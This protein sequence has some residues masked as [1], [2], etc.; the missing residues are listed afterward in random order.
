MINPYPCVKL[1]DGVECYLKEEN[2]L[3]TSYKVR[4]NSSFTTRYLG[5]N[6]VVGEYVSPRGRKNSPLAILIHGMGDRSVIPCRLIARTLVKKGIA[7]FILY[8][9]FHNYRVP[10]S[11]KG[12]YPRLTSEE[13]FESYQ[14][15]VTDVYQVLDWAGTRPELDLDKIAVVGISFGSFISSISMALDNRIKAGVLIVSGGNSD[16]ITKHSLLL[17]RQYKHN[18]LD[19]QQNQES[20]FQYLSEVAER[21]FDNVAA[22]KSS[23]LTDPMTF[24]SYIKNKPL[25]MINALWDEIIPKV[26]TL[27]LWEACGRP[28]IKWY[29]ATHASIWAWYPLIGPQIAAFLLSAYG[30]DGE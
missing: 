7:S 3:F 1:N 18:H 24:A 11:I 17:R 19:F 28:T 2:S 26:A 16:K 12:R 29:P 22:R 20:Y 23:Y 25:L 10:A 6:M 13:W 27:D 4:F 30:L 15:S 8:L 21:G 5:A 14:M 9:V